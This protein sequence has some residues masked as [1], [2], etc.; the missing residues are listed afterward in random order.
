M[1]E[2]RWI[3]FWRC[4]WL[5]A[6][7][8]WFDYLK[9]KMLP[10]FA[11]QSASLE[12]NVDVSCAYRQLR[13]YSLLYPEQMTAMLS[14]PTQAIPESQV[15]WLTD[16]LPQRMQHCVFIGEIIAPGAARKQL[17]SEQRVWCGRISAALRLNLPVPRVDPAFLGLATLAMWQPMLWPRLQWLFSKTAV[18]AAENLD[19]PHIRSK[20]LETIWQAVL[21]RNQHATNSH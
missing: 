12:A 15:F 2:T 7:D 6:D 19:L 11:A 5:F 21:W 8:S 1:V 13:E 16:A 4:P 3:Q 20:A 10:Y 14:L 17:T 9:H 18:E